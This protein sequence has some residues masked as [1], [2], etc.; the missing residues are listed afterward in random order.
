MI[1]RQLRGLSAAPGAIKKS[2]LNEI[3]LVDVFERALIFLNGRRKG[4]N[5]YGTSSKLFNNREQDLSIH[6]VKPCRIHTQPS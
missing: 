3:G 1:E 6:F 5:P 4:L 2:G